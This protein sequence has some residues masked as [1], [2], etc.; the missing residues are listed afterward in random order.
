MRA[1]NGQES[2]W[3]QA[4]INERVGRVRVAGTNYEVSFEPAGDD[5]SDAI[6]AGYEAKYPRST[7]VPIMQGAGRKTQHNKFG[8]I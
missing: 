1:A 2:R 3:Y 4:A 5:V 7:A 6:D 8:A